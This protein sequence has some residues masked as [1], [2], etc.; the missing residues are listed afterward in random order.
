MTEQQTAKQPIFDEATKRGITVDCIN[1]GKLYQFTSGSHV[2]YL[3]N[4]FTSNTS[5]E[6]LLSTNNKKITKTLLE[7]AGLSTP[8]GDL[9]QRNQF[10]SLLKYAKTLEWPLI[11]KPVSGRKGD[12]V[13]VNIKT[14]S[15]LKEAFDTIALQY[16]EVLIEEMFFGTEYR[17]FASRDK[18]LAVAN[19]TP[20]NIIGD[21]VQTIKALIDRKNREMGRLV[22]IKI[23][24]IVSNNLKKRNL[25]LDSVPKKDEQ[26]F[27]RENSNISTG[28]DI[29]DA[30]DDIHPSVGEI[31]V[32]AIN[33]ISGL[34][35]GGV[36]FMTTDVTKKQNANS[37]TILEIN[38]SASI[39]MHQCPT[40]GQSR[41]VA[42]G[43]VDIMFPETVTKIKDKK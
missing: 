25:S 2:E 18:V 38:A 7:K 8:K 26:I 12:C 29:I 22:K 5:A 3:Y 43:I 28:G 20:A 32:R 10:K 17:I 6:A 35:Y 9:F 34:A 27:L 15:E 21:G 4:F 14:E 13:Y 30:T 39:K 19:R 42:G 40:L 37:Y 31:A 24:E 41:N 36:D 16:E 1:V 11:L 23:D 33:A